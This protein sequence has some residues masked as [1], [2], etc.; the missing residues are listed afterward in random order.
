MSFSVWQV[1]DGISYT[2]EN[3]F[4][5]SQDCSHYD[6]LLSR[7]HCLPFPRVGKENSRRISWEGIPEGAI[8]LLQS[9]AVGVSLAHQLTIQVRWRPGQT[10]MV[11]S[12]VLAYFRHEQWRV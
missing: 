10:S 9:F 4:F 8:E 1:S 11:M 3:L 7:L 6:F 12:T 2:K 5:H